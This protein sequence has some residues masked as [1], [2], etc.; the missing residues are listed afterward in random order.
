MAA[1]RVVVADDHPVTRE[2]LRNF[3]EKAVD[4]EVVGEANNG[5]EVLCLVEELAPD[6]L[7]LDMEMPDLSG[8]E[9]AWQLQAAKTAARILALSAHDDKQYIQGLLA[10]GAAGY[11]TKEEAPQTIVEAVRGVARG[12]RGWVSRQV[13]AQMA[14]W[15]QEDTQEKVLTERELEVLKMVAAGKTNQEIGLVLDISEKTVE[16]HMDGIFTK[17][18]VSSRVEAAVY[19]VRNGLV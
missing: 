4:I 19:A 5:T 2:G 6:V 12:E 9:I 18:H 3:L 13:A 16:K 1:I 8:V 15:T 7:L 17:L 10:S 14:A 11:L